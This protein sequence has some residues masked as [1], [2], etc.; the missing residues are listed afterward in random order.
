MKKEIYETDIE[1]MLREEIEKRGF[2]RGKDFAIQYPIRYSFIIDVAFPKQMIAIEADG[3]HYHTSK[4]AKQRDYFK[5]KILKR[6]GWKVIRF[7]GEEIRNNV[8]GCVDKIEKE[9]I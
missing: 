2:E 1:K 9:L 6:L 4:K 3:E 7:W 5:N 8:I